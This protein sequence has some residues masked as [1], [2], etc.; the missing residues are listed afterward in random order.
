MMNA[1]VDNELLAQPV[2]PNLYYPRIHGRSQ[3]RW[4]LKKTKFAE[5]LNF[6]IKSGS[7]RGAPLLAGNTVNS[8]RDGATH[9]VV[10][11]VPIGEENVGSFEV[12][13]TTAFSAVIG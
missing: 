8:S 10:F 4:N 12:K 11:D 1:E 3:T 5:E 9:V 7:K 6:R 2:D 13:L